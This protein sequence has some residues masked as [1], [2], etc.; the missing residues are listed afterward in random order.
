MPGA[1]RDSQMSIFWYLVAM[2]LLLRTGLT[3]FFIPYASLVYADK[4]DM[5]S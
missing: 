5:K 4:E 3:M 1:F 2:N